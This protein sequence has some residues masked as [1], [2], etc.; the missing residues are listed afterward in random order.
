M[1][2]LGTYKDRFGETGQRVF[3]Y[4]MK[5]SRRRDQ[6]YISVEHIIEALGIEES[7]LFNSLMRDLSLDPRAVRV[8]IERRLESGRQHVG[9]G[10]RIAPETNDLFRRALERHEATVARQLSRPIC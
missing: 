8:Q 6:N 4:A 9:K 7:E 10:V 5:E 3:D 1:V 2:D